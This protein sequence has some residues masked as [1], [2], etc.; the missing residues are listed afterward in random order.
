MDPIAGTRDTAD[1]PLFRRDG[2]RFVPSAKTRGPWDPNAMHGGAPSALLAH[3][4]SGFEPGSTT[5]VGR[6]TVELMRPVPLVPLTVAVEVVRPGKKVQLVDAVIRV[7]DTELVR[8][9]ALRLREIDLPTDDAVM[10]GDVMEPGP[11]GS[12]PFDSRTFIESEGFFHAFDVA[13]A[14][15]AW[16][17]P[18]PAAMWFRLRSE[19]VAGEP[20]VPFSRVA[21]ASDFSN[22]LGNAFPWGG[23]LFIN[24]DLTVTV[25]RP[26]VS[27]W[28]GIDAQSVVGPNGTGFAESA[29]YD[30][31]GRIGRATQSLLLDRL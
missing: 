5:F 31:Q 22:G 3:V 1:E 29:V 25:A 19:V 24:P 4:I 2:N 21:A 26:P 28:V 10:T 18:G 17:R 23:Y 20:V 12:T 7:G 15:G 30:E 16:G 6:M 9:R 13:L 27:E 14:R 8:A 11:A